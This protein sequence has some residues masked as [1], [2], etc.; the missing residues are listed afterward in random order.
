MPKQHARSGVVI[1]SRA[2]ERPLEECSILVAGREHRRRRNVCGVPVVDRRGS[3]SE[4]AEDIEV[5]RE[6]KYRKEKG[7]QIQELGIEDRYLD[8][9]SAS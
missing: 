2:T 4:A 5:V 9:I 3:Q 1:R 8:S 7:S 6:T